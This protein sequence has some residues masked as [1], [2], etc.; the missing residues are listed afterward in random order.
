MQPPPYILFREICNR[1]LSLFI[2]L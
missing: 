1:H 2:C